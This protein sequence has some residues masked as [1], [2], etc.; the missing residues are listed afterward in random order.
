LELDGDVPP[1]ALSTAL[2]RAYDLY[3]ELMAH[4]QG[5]S[6][7]RNGWKGVEDIISELAREFPWQLR[8]VH[9][10]LQSGY[11]PAEQCATRL[12]VEA[13]RRLVQAF[14]VLSAQAEGGDASE[15]ERALERHAS[16]SMSQRRL[17]GQ[18]LLRLVQGELIDFEAIAA[19]DAPTDERDAPDEARVPTVVSQDASMPVEQGAEPTEFEE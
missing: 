18:V 17:Y 13:L 3:S 8:R 15:L 10:E 19:G 9:L 6:G 5:A 1:N 12:S 14:A 7:R 2:F 4:L 11:L 16:Q